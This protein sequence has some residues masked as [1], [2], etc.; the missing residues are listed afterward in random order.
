MD[1]KGYLG[2]SEESWRILQE[3]IETGKITLKEGGIRQATTTEVLM[4]AR[5]IASLKPPRLRRI[6]LPEW[7]PPVT[8]IAAKDSPA[9]D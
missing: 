7:T 3:V 2:L 4:T 9:K 8:R 5:Y 6:D 1:E